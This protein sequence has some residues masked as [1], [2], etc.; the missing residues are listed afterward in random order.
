[1]PR[2]R[3]PLRFS[4]SVMPPPFSLPCHTDAAAIIYAF[5]LCC[6]LIAFAYAFDE[7][8]SPLPLLF[9]HSA[10][11]DIAAYAARYDLI[12]MLLMLMIF[13]FYY[14]AADAESRLLRA[15]FATRCRLRFFDT[16]DFYYAIF[17]AAIF[18][19]ATLSR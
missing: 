15:P 3:Q 13:S 9:L 5:S 6:L 10:V 11:M 12:T 2:C 7:A 16:D 18:S 4:R 8:A 17:D 1:M 19:F 14:F